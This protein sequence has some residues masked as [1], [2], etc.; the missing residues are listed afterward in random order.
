M[1]YDKCVKFNQRQNFK[2]HLWNLSFNT[3]IMGII[4]YWRVFHYSQVKW[5]VN[6]T[7]RWLL[8]L[9][10]NNLQRQEAEPYIRT[11]TD[12]FSYQIKY[13]ELW[14]VFLV[15]NCKLSVYQYISKLFCVQMRT[16]RKKNS[17]FKDTVQTEHMVWW[18]CQQ[19]S[20]CYNLAIHM[21]NVW[22]R[23]K[24]ARGFHL[25]R[26]IYKCSHFCMSMTKKFTIST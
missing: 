5:A 3:V 26:L 10:L 20:K 6:F 17:N 7:W 22:T 18:W 19:G 24:G 9:E 12:S 1:C 14:Q 21:T 16:G 4:L 23:N 8:L 15:P 25:Y 11:Q 13:S 2:I